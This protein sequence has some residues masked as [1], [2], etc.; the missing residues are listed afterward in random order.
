VGNSSRKVLHAEGNLWDTL[1]G[2]HIT[3]AAFHV[4]NKQ[5]NEQTDR[6]TAGHRHCV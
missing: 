1:G 6:Q 4:T 2:G 5:T 3:A